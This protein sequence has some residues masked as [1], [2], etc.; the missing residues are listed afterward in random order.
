MSTNRA[1]SNL[2]V[3]MMALPIVVAAP[4]SYLRPD[5]AW[6]YAICI[7]FLPAAWMLKTRFKNADARSR[8][9]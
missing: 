7:L 3:A 5:R 9:A 4:L 2:A 1:L 6:I 8:I